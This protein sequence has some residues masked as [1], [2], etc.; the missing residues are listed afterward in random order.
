MAMDFSCPDQFFAPRRR[1]SG[2]EHHSPI[3]LERMHCHNVL[4]I[5]HGLRTASIGSSQA[6]TA[7]LEKSGTVQSSA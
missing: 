3:N 5:E 1:R 4:A 7:A 6:L 2:L